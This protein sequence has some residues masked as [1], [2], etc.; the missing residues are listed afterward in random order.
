M[1]EPVVDPGWWRYISFWGGMA[2][3][4][5]I[6]Y[7]VIE[8]FAVRKGTEHAIRKVLEDMKRGHRS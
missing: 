5:L 6:T 8:Y 3:G 2:V 7:G 4:C 1:G